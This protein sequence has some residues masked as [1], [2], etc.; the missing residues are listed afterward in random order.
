MDAYELRYRSECFPDDDLPRE[1]R[2][3]ICAQHNVGF[4]PEEGCPVCR[5]LIDPPDAE[6][7]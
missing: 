3:T 4:D 6:Q 2:I 1:Y 7:T 5:G